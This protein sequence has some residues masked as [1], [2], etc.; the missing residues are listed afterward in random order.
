MKGRGACGRA[1]RGRKDCLP[2][3]SRGD[4]APGVRSGPPGQTPNRRCAGA[5]RNRRSARLG[6]ARL[7]SARLGFIIAQ[8]ASGPATGIRKGIC[9]DAMAQSS[10]IAGPAGNSRADPHEIRFHRIGGIAMIRFRRFLA[11]NRLSVRAWAAGAA[12]RF[13]LQGNDEDGRHCARHG[14]PRKARPGAGPLRLPMRK[15]GVPLIRRAMGCDP[16][17]GYRLFYS[18]DPTKRDASTV[19]RGSLRFCRQAS[20]ATQGRNSPE[21]AVSS[22]GGSAYPARPAPAL[23]ALP[24]RARQQSARR[25]ARGRRREGSFPDLGRDRALPGHSG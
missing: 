16:L 17:P 25:S 4:G 2:E 6:S 11:D 9:R 20:Q 22:P 12:L 5:R 3:R 1:R 8:K 15:H 21:S 18:G 10:P 19:A 24:G 14:G 23:A 7:G 13:A